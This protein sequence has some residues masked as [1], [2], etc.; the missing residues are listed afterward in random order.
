MVS[1]PDAEPV[2]ADSTL[3]ATASETSGPPPRPSTQSRTR[4]KAG[5]AATTAP[6]P[7]RLATLSAGKTA[8]LAPASMLA[9]VL[10]SRLPL[11]S[12]RV[13]IA[14]A[15]AAATDQTPPTADSDVAPQ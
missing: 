10:G 3:V 4:A 1:P 6:K 5:R 7:T 13:T 15:S 11:T 14:A 8:A 12:S 2:R 9:R